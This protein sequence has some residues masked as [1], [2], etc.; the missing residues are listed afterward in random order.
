V[1][2]NAEYGV[3]VRKID[4]ETPPRADSS[5]RTGMETQLWQVFRGSA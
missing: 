3:A 5:V 4:H 2:S 1:R